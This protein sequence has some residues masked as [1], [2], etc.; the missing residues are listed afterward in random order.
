MILV[1]TSVWIDH[2]H[3]GNEALARVLEAGAVLGHPWVIGELALGRLSRRAEVLRLLGGLPQAT[4][5]TETEV[6]GLIEREALSGSGIGYVDAQLLAAG[7]LTSA[8]LWTGDRRLATVAA[9][10]GIAFDPHSAG[11]AGE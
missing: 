1:D 10:L 4:A 5:A 7:R 6:L 9:R 2:L 3:A 11:R 8:R